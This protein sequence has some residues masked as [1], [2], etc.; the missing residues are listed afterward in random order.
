MCLIFQ[1]WCGFQS[2]IKAF[3]AKME[4]RAEEELL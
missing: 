2:L 1:R 4:K 3:A